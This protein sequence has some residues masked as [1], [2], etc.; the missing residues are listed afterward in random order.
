MNRHLCVLV[1]SVA[2]GLLLLACAGG[3]SPAPAGSL[4]LDAA[5]SVLTAIAIKNEVKPVPVHFAGLSG[6]ADPISGTAEL[7][8]PLL[9]LATGD[10]ARDTN[11]R[12]LFFEADQ[13]RFATARFKLDKVDADLGGM[14]SGQTVTAQAHGSLSLHGA[15]LALEGPLSLWKD[16]GSVTVTLGQGW[17]VAI[18]KTSLVAALANLNQHCPQPHRVGNDVALSGSLVFVP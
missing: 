1:P 2:A 12:T 4:H 15:D 10:A 11:V 3:K 14:A 16:G 13:S 6:W 9:S 7:A 8:I 18:T 5:H 17:S